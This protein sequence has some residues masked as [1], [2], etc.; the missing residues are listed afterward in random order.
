MS[1]RGL[2]AIPVDESGNPLGHGGGDPISV[3]VTNTVATAGGGIA[4][5]Y[6]YYYGGSAAFAFPVFDDTEYH[7]AGT[8]NGAMHV[9]LRDASGN[10]ITSL[11]G[12][13]GAVDESA[14]TEGTTEFT[15]IGG[16]FNDSLV[17]DPASGEAA[18][19]RITSDRALHTNLRNATGTEVG[20]ASAPLRVDPTG[21]T[22]QPVS[23][24]T[25]P[26]GTNNIGDV[27]VLTL[28][29]G[30]LSIPK[31]VSTS[32]TRPN[33]TTAYAA[34]DAVTDSTSSPTALTFSAVATANGG[35]GI[36]LGALMLDSAN[37][38]TK[39][40]FELWLFT[41]SAAPTPDNDNSAFTPTDAELAN[42]VAIIP[43]SAVYVGDA[44]S[45]A[46]GN[47]IYESPEMARPFV[48]DGS[49][50]DLFGLLVVRNAYTPVGQEVF[51]IILRVVQT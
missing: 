4:R 22:T 19:A 50:D 16:V 41:G 36:V 24:S 33:D 37:Q 32:V 9:N 11:G 31:Q 18:A 6:V 27:D 44:T 51:T 25:L 35:K 29:S 14:F 13:A 45:G 3:E 46:G 20:T 5:A 49:V 39:G 23:L 48:C 42:L 2:P 10:E 34:G 38:S 28:P 8:A 21:S 15:P 7:V 43:L 17:S 47:A 40:V 1:A 26:A 12:G 30:A